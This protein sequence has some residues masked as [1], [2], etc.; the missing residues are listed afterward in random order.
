MKKLLLIFSLASIISCQVLDQKQHTAATTFLVPLGNTIT[1]S[2]VA[3]TL[4]AVLEDSRC[5]RNTTCIWE[6]RAVVKISI[7]Q[8][9]QKIRDVIVVFKNQEQSI[10]TRTEDAVFTALKL[11]PYPGGATNKELGY[12]LQVSYKKSTN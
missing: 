2:G 4:D 7:T 11:L 5:P 6:G 12:Q 9:K 1:T 8:P 3:I 10:I